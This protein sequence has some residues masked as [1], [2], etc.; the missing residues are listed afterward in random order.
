M[1]KYFVI[2]GIV[3]AALAFS[4]CVGDST[5]T[6][7]YTDPVPYLTAVTVTERIPADT[8]SEYMATYTTTQPTG[9]DV[10]YYSVSRGNSLRADTGISAAVSADK[11][12]NADIPRDTAVT[13]A[14]TDKSVTDTSVTETSLPDGEI[15]A[16][17]EVP[18]SEETEQTSETTKHTMPPRPSADTAAVQKV[19]ADTKYSEEQTSATTTSNGGTTDAD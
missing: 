14:L 15:S 13:R 18:I 4:G 8:Y 16:E 9:T 11:S 7:V 5:R 1:K 12:H 3:F 6:V 10:Y 19:S 2:F 17:T